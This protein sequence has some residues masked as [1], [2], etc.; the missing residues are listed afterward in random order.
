MASGEIYKKEKRM[1]EFSEAYPNLVTKQTILKPEELEP[2]LNHA[3]QMAALD[4][5]VAI[6][7]DIFVPTYEGNMA[8][9]VEGH[10]RYL[11]FKTT[12]TLDRKLLFSLIDE[13]RNGSMNWDGFSVL[14]KKSHE[15]RRGK[16]TKRI[17]IP[18]YPRQEDYFYS[19]PQ[20]CLPPFAQPSSSSS[21]TP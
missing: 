14:V 19:N 10:R 8:K 3:D 18:D 12:I 13:Y 21:T 2:F 11:G 16:P 4:Y 5:I 9:A 7:S 15:E 20:E 17:E 6:E 1:A